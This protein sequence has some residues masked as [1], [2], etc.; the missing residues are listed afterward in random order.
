MQAPESNGDLTPIPASDHAAATDAGVVLELLRSLVSIDSQNPELVAGGAGERETA[1]Y[2]REQL[3][4]SGGE[5]WLDEVAP[6]RWN[7]VGRVSG[8]PGPTLV[9]CAHLDTVSA[10]RMSTPPSAPRPEQER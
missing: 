1:E 6:G 2:C 4:C 9:L 10:A 7:A 5:S 8:G 3:L